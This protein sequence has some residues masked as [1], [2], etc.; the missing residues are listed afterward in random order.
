MPSTP[1][2]GLVEYLQ[3]AF[4]G[5]GSACKR[6]SKFLPLPFKIK[7]PLPAFKVQRAYGRL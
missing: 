4:T 5:R 1:F 2:K 6:S 7:M 3:N